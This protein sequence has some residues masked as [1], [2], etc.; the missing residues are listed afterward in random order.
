MRLGIVW[1][2][3][4]LVG[5]KTEIYPLMVALFCNTVHNMHETY[6]FRRYRNA[7]LFFRFP[8]RSEVSRLRTIYMT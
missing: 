7:H 8:Y 4:P 5:Y 6:S 1:F 3:L 2:T